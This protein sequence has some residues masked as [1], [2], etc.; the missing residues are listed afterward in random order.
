MP[1]CRFVSARTVPLAFASLLGMFAAGC[2]E[3]DAIRVAEEATPAKVAPPTVP[4]DQQQF[5]TLAVMLPQGGEGGWWFFK[6]SGPAEVVAKHEAAFRAVAG[7]IRFTGEKANPI[8]WDT[9]PGW[10]RV[11]GLPARFA[12]LRQDNKDNATVEIAISQAGGTVLM[13]VNRWRKQLGLAD[14]NPAALDTV[15]PVRSVNGRTAVFVDMSGPQYKAPGP[16]GMIP[17]H[18]G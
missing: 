4:P 8:T 10:V 9:P 15:A 16:G 13:N 18:G 12:T 7:S 6:F 17:G 11:D 5:R 14:V 2:A 1:F 3:P